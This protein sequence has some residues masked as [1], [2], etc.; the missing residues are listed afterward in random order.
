MCTL[1]GSLLPWKFTF[2]YLGKSL[3]AQ[4][5]EFD[6]ERFGDVMQRILLPMALDYHVRSREIDIN[7]LAADQLA[8]LNGD[9][10]E[11]NEA[12]EVRV[13][14]V[15]FTNLTLF[16]CLLAK[17]PGAFLTSTSNL[18]HLID[19]FESRKPHNV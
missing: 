17:F 3:Y 9:D 15:N 5:S 18:Q 4:A 6:D 13:L 2:F 12:I 19:P 7:E 14:P 8:K 11:K 16:V 1:S 10:D